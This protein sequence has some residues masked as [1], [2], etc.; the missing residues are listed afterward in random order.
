MNLGCIHLSVSEHIEQMLIWV[1]TCVST[2]WNNFFH[3]EI[4]SPQRDP[5][6]L[7]TKDYMQKRFNRICKGGK[8]D[9]MPIFDQNS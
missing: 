4:K 5:R 2:V 8:I 6:N 1:Q 7:L 3:E 9:V